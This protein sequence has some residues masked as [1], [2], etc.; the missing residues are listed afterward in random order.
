MWGVARKSTQRHIG[1]HNLSTDYT[2]F[3][4]VMQL[5]GKGTLQI[6]RMTHWNTGLHSYRRFGGRRGLY[7]IFSTGQ[8][9]LVHMSML[10][11]L[12]IRFKFRLPSF[13][14][15]IYIYAYLYCVKICC[16]YEIEYIYE[17]LEHK[18]VS[19]GISV[20]DVYVC[21]RG[22]R[23]HA[24]RQVGIVEEVSLLLLL[25]HLQ[26]KRKILGIGDKS[27]IKQF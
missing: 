27:Q 5:L 21:V 14:N 2:I 3:H 12:K 18:K 20:L 26:R 4:R 8:L 9:I 13:N 1:R 25:F 17:F 15:M 11:P 10:S 6:S 22:V 19:P 24:D 7:S 23:V 16:L